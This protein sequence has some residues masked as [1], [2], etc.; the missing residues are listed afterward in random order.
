LGHAQK[1]ESIIENSAAVGE[2]HGRVMVEASKQNMPVE[3]AKS[4]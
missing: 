1:L 3:S 4:R 2:R